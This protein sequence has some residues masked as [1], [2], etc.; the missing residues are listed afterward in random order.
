[1][2]AFADALARVLIHE[3]GYVNHP[4]DPGGATNRGVIQRVYDGYRKRN[5]L[6]TRS[7]HLI[8]DAEVSDIYRRQYWDAVKGDQLPAGV[9]YVVFDG[10][11]NSGPVQSIKWLQR[12]L[13]VVDDGVI[14]NVT[15]AAVDA[16][17][18]HDAL[19]AEICDRRLKFLKA[20]RHWP[21]FGRGWTSRVF[22]VLAA[23][24]A[25]ASGSVVP[26]ARFVSGGEAK[27]LPSDAKEAPTTGVAD[28][29]AG[30]GA[31]VIVALSAIKDQLQPYTSVSRWIEMAVIGLIVVG[32]AIAVGGILY[33]LWANRRRAQLTEALGAKP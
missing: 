14:G 25:M 12:A 2:S 26:P 1:M 27:A 23:G 33:R 20:L 29:A 22:G 21:T 5:G 31:G 16:H 28:A 3:G 9:S 24:Q 13:G 10:A 11:V 4:A 6:A 8:T 32:G 15:L 30:G 19:I 7:V 17:P 18:D